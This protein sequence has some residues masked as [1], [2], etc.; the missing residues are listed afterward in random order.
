MFNKSRRVNERYKKFAMYD[1]H[2]FSGEELVI[3]FSL[4]SFEGYSSF[5]GAMHDTQKKRCAVHSDI[6]KGLAL[7]LKCFD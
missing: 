1:K 6:R 5:S 3:E 4:L 2:S 7:A